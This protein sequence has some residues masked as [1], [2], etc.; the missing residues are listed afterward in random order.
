MKTQVEWYSVC[1]D[2]M[3]FINKE[4]AKL[5]PPKYQIVDIKFVNNAS[6]SQQNEMLVIYNEYEV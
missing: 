6:Y 4:L 2:T 3:D 5:Q 1:S